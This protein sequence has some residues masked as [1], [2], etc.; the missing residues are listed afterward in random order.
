MLDRELIALEV[1]FAV[2]RIGA[3]ERD[4]EADERGVA[5]DALGIVADRGLGGPGG[6]GLDE[7]QCA[8]RHG[9]FEHAPPAHAVKTGLRHGFLLLGRVGS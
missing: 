6:Q 2:G 7:G 3:G 1:V 5:L 4:G 9:A 8:Q